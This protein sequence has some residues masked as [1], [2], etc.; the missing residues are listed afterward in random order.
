MEYEVIDLENWKR[1]E[2][3]NFFKTFEE[4]FTGIVAD[5]NV[6][7]AK[8]FCKANQLSFFQYYLHKSITAVNQTEAFRLRIINNEVRKYS[9]VH[10]SATISRKD[11]TFGFSH[12]VYDANFEV[13][14]QNVENEKNRI[15]QDRSLFP[16]QGSDNVVHYS[17]MP[18]IKF[19]SVSHARKFSLEDASP[20][21]SFGRVYED[22][23]NE[24]LMPVS[25]HVHHALVDGRDIAEYLACFQKCLNGVH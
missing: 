23:K 24:L 11:D 17:S 18:W 16:P 4:P 19:R 6:S 14:A 9:C 7:F 13:F 10:A 15:E 22:V 12:I 25:V 5:V 21:I 2:H 3:F 8:E 1:K 20:K